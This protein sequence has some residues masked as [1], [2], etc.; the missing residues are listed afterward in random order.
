MKRKIII[1]RYGEIGLKA[2][3]TRKQFEGKLIQNLKEALDRKEINNK[4]SKEYGRIYLDT[5]KVNEAI[6]IIT[7]IFGI[8]SVSKAVKTKSD[9]Y[10]M[11]KKALEIAK[12][13]LIKNK[14]FALRV[15]REGNHDFTSQDIA[16]KFGDSIL[17][18]TQ[19]KVNLTKPDF[20]LF[21][22]IRNEYA[23]FYTTKIKGPGGLPL[24][25]QG[26]VLSLIENNNS[27]LAAWYII[28]RGCKP[29][30]IIN[31]INMIKKINLFS[32]KWN[33]HNQRIIHI[34]D[35]KINNIAQ[36][37]NCDAIVTGHSINS[38]SKK[39]IN[40][41]KDL[42][43]KLKIPIL[44]PLISMNEKEITQKIK[45]IDLLK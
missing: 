17:K 5:T 29:I 20:I 10:E 11:E 42:K 39:E 12:K 4:I 34:K 32:E 15:N 2:K 28:R 45:E 43:I 40:E 6:K 7:R 26:N 35:E 3:Y 38:T 1:I 9:I 24:G 23:Y 37:N 21:I 31:N 27:L 16:I 30:F 41:I 33:I 18:N 8:I 22:E 13:Y 19:A 36:K 44:T 14:T 25:T